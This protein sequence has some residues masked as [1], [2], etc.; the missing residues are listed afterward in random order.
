MARRQAMRSIDG[1]HVHYAAGSISAV[2]SAREI[3]AIRRTLPLR[4]V[5]LPS[6]HC[7]ALQPRVMEQIPI[8]TIMANAYG[9]FLISAARQPSP[10]DLTCAVITLL[11]CII[12]FDT[13]DGQGTLIAAC[14]NAGFHLEIT[15]IHSNEQA[16]ENLDRQGAKFL[17]TF[18][19]ENSRNLY[20]HHSD[21]KVLM[22]GIIL[23]AMVKN[24]TPEGYDGWMKNRVRGFAGSLG[25]TEDNHCWSESQW[26]IQEALSCF[27]SFMSANHGLRHR[28]FMVCVAVSRNSSRIANLFRDVLNLLRGS[29]MNHYILIDCYIF[30]KYPELLMIRQL[31]DDMTL[32]NNATA[33]LHSLHP[34]EMMYVRILKTKDETAVLNRNNF[35][36][37]AAAATIVAQFEHQSFRFYR[38]GSEGQIHSTLKYVITSYLTMRLNF[39]PHTMTLS[40]YAQA[41]EEEKAHIL[42][43]ILAPEE[44]RTHMG[45]LRPADAPGIEA[46]NLQLPGN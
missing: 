13:V 26:P 34:G 18:D 33:F 12:P 5:N 19:T 27:Q 1:L 4:E 44:G 36:I 17:G 11:N 14:V 28:L 39:S 7:Y 24:I 8:G 15:R 38:G 22:L 43:E 6:H 46:R 40:H 20:L 3:P 16:L 32:Y 23:C 35:R 37:L 31:R 29:E 45:L 10:Y 41:S 21:Q 2:A 9:R 42:R 30:G 25:M